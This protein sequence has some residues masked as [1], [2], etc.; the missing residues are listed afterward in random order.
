MAQVAVQEHNM[1]LT[2]NHQTNE[3]SNDGVITVGGVAVGGDNT[4]KWYGARY[5]HAGGASTVNVMDYVTIQTTGNATDFGDLTVGRY[6]GAG[7]SNGSRGVFGG[8]YTGSNQDVIDYITIGTTGNAT[9]FGNMSVARR[10]MGSLSNGTRGVFAG[11]EGGNSNVMDYI[12]ISTTGNATD[13]GDLTQNS[14]DGSAGVCDGTIGVFT[15]IGDDLY[16]TEKIIV[17]TAGNAT[18]YGALSYYFT[19]ATSNISDTTYGVF[20][21]GLNQGSESR[22]ER[23]TIATNGNGTDIGDL[24]THNKDIGGG[25]GDASRGIVAGGDASASGPSNVIQY[26]TIAASSGNA[27]DFGDLTRGVYRAAGGAAGT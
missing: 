10:R 19:D 7:T 16:R 5:V 24:N 27:V 17:A 18:D 12:T 1:A 4:P 2:F 21:A 11:G 9:D 20:C 6:L 26:L 3:I 8:G 13:F 15:T 14:A 23:I 25:G 22:I